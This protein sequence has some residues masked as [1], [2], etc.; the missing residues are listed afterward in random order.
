MQQASVSRDWTFYGR[1]G[2]DCCATAAGFLMA[3]LRGHRLT[4]RMVDVQG[5]PA[6]GPHAIPAFSDPAGKMVWEGSFDSEATR[7]ALEAWGLMRL[8]HEQ[9]GV[10]AP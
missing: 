10:A 9:E 6:G 5:H 1:E 8:P 2:C 3:L 7:M 4:V